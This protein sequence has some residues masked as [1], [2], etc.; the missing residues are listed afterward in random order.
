ML[1]FKLDEETKASGSER[2]P[3]DG[4]ADL[5]APG[6]PDSGLGASASSPDEIDGEE[7]DTYQC[8]LS[9]ETKKKAETELGET[10]IVHQ[11]AV[12]N[13]RKRMEQRPDIRF[14][15][16]ERFLLRFLRAKKFEVERAFNSIVKYYELHVKHPDFF[17]DYKPSAIKHV[18]DD[19]FPMVLSQLDEEGRPVVAMKAGT[20]GDDSSISASIAIKTLCNL[21]ML[22]LQY[23]FISILHSPPPTP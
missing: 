20:M 14:C 15:Q 10:D 1:A 19:G 7:F 2:T 13:L 23:K 16:D 22:D 17:K 8:T 3:P 4:S 11:L 21:K 5:P 6:S 12:M 18:L 9:P